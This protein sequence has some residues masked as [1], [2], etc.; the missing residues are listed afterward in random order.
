[1]KI[2]GEEV[3]V[4]RHS[5]NTE[6][7]LIYA[8]LRS[9]LAQVPEPIGRLISAEHETPLKTAFIGHLAK[10]PLLDMSE[11]LHH[12][13]NAIPELSIA[14]TDNCTLRCVYCHASAGEPHKLATMS[15]EVVD[16]PTFLKLLT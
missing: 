1:M 15:T 7:C 11:V 6:K 12:L 8:P 9:Y 2:A 16:A 10:R 5:S 3:F 13:H 4:V 14:I